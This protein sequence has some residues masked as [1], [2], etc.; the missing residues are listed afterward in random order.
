VT[1]YIVSGFAFLAL[2]CTGPSQTSDPSAAGSS[3]G[4]A[5]AAGTGGAGTAGTTAGAAQAGVSGSAGASSAGAAGSAGAS[6]S[7]SGGAAGSGGM[8]GAAGGTGTCSPSYLLC[9]DFESTAVGATPSGWTAKGMASVAEDQANQ[10]KRS[11]KVSPE[12]D[13]ERRIT[14]DAAVLGG[15]HWGRIYYRVQ[16]P[17]PEAFVHSTLV[18]FSGE[19]PTIGAAEFRFVDTVKQ[20]GGAGAK[21]QFLYNVQPQNS[22]EF[23][24]QGPYDWSFDGQWHCVEWHVDSAD[25]SY[26][27]YFE[28]SEEIAFSHGAGN[29]N[30]SQLPTSFDEVRI[31]WNNYQSAPPGFTAWI[32]DVALDDERVGC[33]P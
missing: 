2:A 12:D 14:H 5:G 21:H 13:G 1:T 20:Q 22:G 19:G 10:G 7:A 32:D 29:F 30:G 11:L 6:G 28:G 18:A 16:L 23:A 3:Q 15:Q 33:L 31:G 27:F 9:E 4:G 8:A 24:T 26:Q 25:Q 17:A